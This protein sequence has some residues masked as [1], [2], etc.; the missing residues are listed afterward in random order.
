[1][2]GI[3]KCVLGFRVFHITSYLKVHFNT[4]WQA[5]GGASNDAN[6]FKVLVLAY[7]KFINVVGLQH[8]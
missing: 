8:F 6:H 7:V 1:M 2:C 3:K 4:L 5:F